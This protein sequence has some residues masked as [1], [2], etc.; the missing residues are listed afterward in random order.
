M[1]HK[2][3]VDTKLVD[4]KPGDTLQITE[5][6]AAGIHKVIV[7]IHR[8]TEDEVAGI[9]K[10]IPVEVEAVTFLEVDTVDK[11]VVMKVDVVVMCQE[12]GMRREGVMRHE[13]VMCHEVVTCRG[14]REVVPEV[15][16][17]MMLAGSLITT[18]S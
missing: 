3:E 18:L 1:V 17:T 10:V 12:V 16:I 14:A 8:T 6:G 13:A 5:A 9:R 4:T 2:T 11:E 15:G 7:D